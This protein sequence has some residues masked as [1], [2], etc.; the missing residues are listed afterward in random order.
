MV[1]SCS[2]FFKYRNLKGLKMKKTILSVLALTLICSVSNANT[3]EDNQKN[4]IN[5]PCTENAPCHKK[6]CPKCMIEDDEYCVYNECFFDKQFRQMK[7]A[8]CL[9]PEQENC[10]NNIYKNF[11]ADFEA[12]HSKYRTQ[13]NKLLDMIACN[14]DCYKDQEKYLKEIKKEC[15]EKLKDYDD[16]IK[17]Q[18]CKN[19]RS[20]YRKFKRQEKKKMKKFIKYG[21]I[22]KLPCTE[23]PENCN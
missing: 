21:A 17:E 7:T 1:Y 20:E 22:Y 2:V 10:I 9:T 14:N 4:S 19:Q 13:K 15:K 5:Q 6:G 23:C 16:D 18:L 12:T 8:L 3:C 11:K